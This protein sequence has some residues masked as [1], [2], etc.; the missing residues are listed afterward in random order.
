[1][2]NEISEKVLNSNLPDALKDRHAD[3]FYDQTKPYD[4]SIQSIFQAYSV[5]VLMQSIKAASRA[6]RNSDYA[7]PQIKRELLREILRSWEQLSSVLLALTPL[8]ATNGNAV[9][10]GANFELYGNFGETYENR[11]KT[12]L[13]NIPF[14]VVSWFRNDIFSHKIGPLLFDQIANETN[15]LKRHELILLLVYQ[16]PRE[17]K[18]Q[19]ENYIASISKNSFFLADIVNVLCGQYRYSF[20]SPRT[21]KEIEYLIKMGMA[22]HEWGRNRPAL[23]AI[24]KIS[25]KLLPKRQVDDEDPKLSSGS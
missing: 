11:V 3:L 7:N 23:E 13:Q 24:T 15:D 17:W 22:K 25:N 20:A 9:F 6:L 4:Q 18:T 12:I 10:E 14:N 16:R 1:M 8:L 19:V 5:V 2:R 21:L